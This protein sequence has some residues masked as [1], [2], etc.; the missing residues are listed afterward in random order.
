MDR[1]YRIGNLVGLPDVLYPGQ[2]KTVLGLP[3]VAFRFPG[4]SGEV[5]VPPG[6]VHLDLPREPP[7]RS[8]VIDRNGRAWQRS[9][10]GCNWYAAECGPL[11]WKILNDLHGELN[12]IYQP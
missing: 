11:S 6:A 3:Y 8:V 5:L 2:A 10:G 12:V 9:A 4:I 1:T 7:A